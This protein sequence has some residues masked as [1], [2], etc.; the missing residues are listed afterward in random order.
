MGRHG[1]IWGLTL[2]VATGCSSTR[3]DEQTP[4]ITSASA[5]IG[6]GTAGQSTTSGETGPDVTTGNVETGAVTGADDASDDSPVKFDLEA[7]DIEVPETTGCDKIDFVFSVDNSC[8]TEDDQATLQQAFAQFV[9]LIRDN[10][11]GQDWHIIVVDSDGDPTWACDN[12]AASCCTGF[13]P[14]SYNFSACDL[15]MGAGVVSPH[16]GQASNTDCGIPAGRRYLTGDDEPLDDMFACVA[17]VGTSGSF[18]EYPI[19]AAVNALQN[20][21]GCNDGFLRDDAILVMTVITD[22]HDGDFSYPGDAENGAPNGWY[23]SIVAAKNGNEDASVFIAL[24]S[25]HCMGPPV[26]PF[27]QIV[28]LFGDQGVQGSNCSLPEMLDTFEAAVMA[29]D[30]TCDGFIPG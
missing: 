1:L 15:E 3:E 27:Q 4:F 20:P 11:Q 9:Q 16:G 2:L 24:T 10:V 14:G 13:A 26:P 29:I 12:G 21:M 6:D 8:S 23:D 30:T 19:T 5:S 25:N 7:E 18:S 22:D 28:Q 17:Q